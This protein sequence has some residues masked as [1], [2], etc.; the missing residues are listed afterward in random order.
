MA[1][2]G[3]NLP[4]RWRV[5]LLLA[6]LATLTVLNTALVRN[7]IL[8]VTSLERVDADL[9]EA[10]GA[11]E[12]LQSSRSDQVLSVRAFALT[13]KPSFRRQYLR[14]RLE[15]GRLEDELRTYLAAEPPLIDQAD[16]GGDAMAAWRRETAEPIIRA[17][18]EERARIGARLVATVGE[19]LF[20]AVR[21][22]EDGLDQAIESRHDQ[23]HS[24]ILAARSRLNV[25]VLATSALAL[26]LVAAAAWVLRRWITV[27][28]AALTAQTDKVVSGDLDTHIH[29]VG[30]VEF[31]RVGANVERMRRRIVNELRATSQALEGLEQRA[32]LVAGIRGQ[33]LASADVEL[34]GGLRVAARLEPA[35]GVLAGDWY[36]L[37]KVDDRRVA[38]AMVDVS[39]HGP[40]AG[41]HALWLKHLLLPAIHMG[42]EP[43][44]ALEW[45]AGEMGVTGEWFATC[46]IISVDS[47]TGECRYANAGHPP[48]LLF[49]PDGV[50]ELPG[51][52]PIFGPLPDQRWR[53]GSVSLGRGDM[54]VLYTDGITE[55]RNQ[56][57]EEFGDER[58]I[59]LVRGERRRDVDRLAEEVMDS[60]HMFGSERL[61]DDATLAL[62]TYGD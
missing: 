62:V 58:L 61:K 49:G 3:I 17:A 38:L 36:D 50:V 10:T 19:P 27:P 25:A 14:Q 35:H 16:Q 30:P 60:V 5:I 56:T 57:G 32:P 24:R 47:V 29:A 8:A 46:V 13:G 34:P 1:A 40:D 31:E 54:L 42:L 53:T 23:V 33:L 37:V 15:E 28:V 7:E 12:R 45:V 20:D 59:S 41:L 26:A 51:T 2:A 52:G 18:P 9:D 4:L 22:E 39:G 21:A 55:A 11:H 43:G 48:P 44:A 6:A